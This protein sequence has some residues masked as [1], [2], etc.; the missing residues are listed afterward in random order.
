MGKNI[1]PVL[2]CILVGLT[3]T[4]CTMCGQ[5]DLDSYGAYGG[6]WH[7]TD[8]DHGRVGSLFI[9]AGAQVPYDETAPAGGEG[10]GGPDDNSMPSPTPQPTPLDDESNSE[11]ATETALLDRMLND[12]F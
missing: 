3:S 8:R 12:D 7:R 6:R 11:P 1:L 10:E 4:G 9:P 5:C 2:A